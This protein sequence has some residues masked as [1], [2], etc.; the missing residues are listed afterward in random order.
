MSA[1]TPWNGADV[2][3]SGVAFAPSLKLNASDLIR[4]LAVATATTATTTTSRDATRDAHDAAGAGAAAA[5]AAA[6]ARM[7]RLRHWVVED[8]SSSNSSHQQDPEEELDGRVECSA[9]DVEVACAAACER[10]LRDV[11]G[12]A[13]MWAP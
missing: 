11:A 8:N 1:C 5:A 2:G 7:E 3:A 13:F 6:N 4:A 9:L 10:A 12:G